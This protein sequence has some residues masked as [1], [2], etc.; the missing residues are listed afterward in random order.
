MKRA[1]RP[2]I[3]GFVALIAGVAPAADS[4]GAPLALTPVAMTGDSLPGAPTASLAGFDHISSTPQ[5]D[6]QGGVA[7][8]SFLEGSGVTGDANTAVVAGRT[9]NLRTVARAV[10]PG[11]YVGNGA[12]ATDRAGNLL[13][14]VRT[15]DLIDVEDDPAANDLREVR[16]IWMA[17]P[18]GGQDGRGSSLNNAGQLALLLDFTDGSSGVFVAS[19][20]PEPASL[21]AALAGLLL[22]VVRRGRSSD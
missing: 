14:I 1:Y 10:A 21:L 8:V 3:V 22:V 11:G 9:G 18:S 20:V 4:I 13:S 5:I 2:L 7:F 12:W 19:V 6:S 17:S 16:S 15:G